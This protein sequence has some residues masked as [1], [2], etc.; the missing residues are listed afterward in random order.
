MADSNVKLS[1]I[2][3]QFKIR[4]SGP[5]AAFQQEPYDST[6]AQR[7]RRKLDSVKVAGEIASYKI[8][9]SEFEALWQ[10]VRSATHLQPTHEIR[11]T[12]GQGCPDLSE[13]I[14][15][16]KSDSDKAIAKISIQADSTVVRKW[17][18]DWFQFFIEE[19]VQA[20]LPQAHIHSAQLNNAFIRA[21]NG[22]SIKKYPLAAHP[23]QPSADEC[24]NT[25]YVLS[26]NKNRSEMI[27]SIFNPVKVINTLS[28]PKLTQII[29]DGCQKLS[30]SAGAP[31]TVRKKEIEQAFECMQ[32]GPEQFGIG[33]PMCLL[34]G[35]SIPKSTGTGPAANYPGAGLLNFQVDDD[36]M[37]AVIVNFDM[38]SYHQ[39]DY[40]IDNEFILR[41]CD[42]AQLHREL[43]KPH[44]RK[45]LNSVSTAHD[46]SGLTIALGDPSRPGS[47]PYIH[48]IYKE[49]Q[50]QQKAKLIEENPDAKV[51][52]REST[53]HQQVKPGE[54]VAEVRYKTS[55]HLGKNVF[56]QK[57]PPAPNPPGKYKIGEG[58]EEREEG[59]FY[60]T[61]EGVPF[62][63]R[64]HIT[65]RRTMKHA[66][67]VNLKSGN[68]DFEGPVEINGSIDSGATVRVGGSLIVKGSIRGG[69][70]IVGGDLKVRNGIVTGEKGF[71]NVG[72]ELYA[73]FIENSNVICAGNF[74]VHKAVLNSTLICGGNVRVEDKKEGVVAGGTI[75]ARYNLVTAQL[76]FHRGNPTHINLGVD[77]K[78]EKAVMTRQNRIQALSEQQAKD[79]SELR[80]VMARKKQAMTA[81]FE[82]KKVY[83]QEKLVRIR[84]VIDKMKI[85]LENAK[86]QMVFDA[87][88]RA[89]VNETCFSS[90]VAFIGGHEVIITQ[91]VAGVALLGKKVRGSTIIPIEDAIK[92]KKEEDEEALAQQ[93]EDEEEEE[94][95]HDVDDDDT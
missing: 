27:L 61:L 30:V 23:K 90:V 14:Q 37:A 74:T 60:A 82:E 63:E 6:V 31:Y 46:L 33:L 10:S 4:V 83:Y 5:V 15:V 45:I 89:F 67:D 36:K 65:I 92:A 47:R 85:H 42:R 21:A 57:L 75:S 22:I 18:M 73:Q 7:A 34:V 2:A 52:L 3:A 80:D 69:T 81:K 17:R 59:K 79:R 29:S 19:K 32:H 88:V 95:N 56:G 94:D 48:P 78:I 66:G 43:V 86:A 64:D 93:E 20:L 91:N 28:I 26:A 87:S 71:V 12:L 11:F 54:L 41:E 16:T 39:A 40:K 55:P 25:P 9:N 53:T 8:Y 84:A 24:E 38:T 35:T 76:G 50:K 70:V 49:L 72:G 13:H 62:I 51:D 44:L 58:I 68:I 1:Y 77:W